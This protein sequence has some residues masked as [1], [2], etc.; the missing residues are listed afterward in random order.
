MNNIQVTT[1]IKVKILCADCNKFLKIQE[2]VPIKGNY[3][4]FKIIQH[5]VIIKPCECQK[6]NTK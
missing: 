6:T 2:I 4:L 5:N 1:D 3:P